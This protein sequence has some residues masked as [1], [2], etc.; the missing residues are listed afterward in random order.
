MAK[1][2]L[3]PGD[4]CPRCRGE[5]VAQRV[6]TDIEYHKAFDKETG[7]GLPEGVDTASPDQRAE[8]GPLFTCSTCGYNHRYGVEKAD[9]PP[10]PKK[11]PAA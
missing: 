2:E 6:P 10:A 9:E 8:L 4:P 11:K 5:L 3:K 7:V 1:G